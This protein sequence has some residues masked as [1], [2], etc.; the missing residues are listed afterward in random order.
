M[1][2]P[3]FDQPIP[4]AG[5]AAAPYPEESRSQ[6]VFVLGL[7]GMFVMPLL[8]PFAW[9]MGNR[10]LAAIDA[11][12]RTPDNRQLAQIGRL[13]GIV[14]STLLILFVVAVLGLIGV[15]L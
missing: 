6:T 5:Y 8:A 11:G 15:S 1:S 14:M 2:E 12:R 10:E 9:R 3:S 4:A 13:L 7:C